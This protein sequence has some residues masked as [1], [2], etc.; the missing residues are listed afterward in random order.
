MLT[1]WNASN[2]IA[3]ADLNAARTVQ[4]I[5]LPGYRLHRLKGDRKEFWS[6]WIS[7]NWRITFRFEDGHAF[8]VDLIDYH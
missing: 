3:L 5:N 8:E 6:I 4:E 2:G 1:R 7:A